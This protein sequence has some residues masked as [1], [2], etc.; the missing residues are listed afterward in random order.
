MQAFG[1][2]RF[3]PKLA[4]FFILTAVDLYRCS[5]QRP[6]WL[7]RQSH[8]LRA[9]AAAVTAGDISGAH[10]A[11]RLRKLAPVGGILGRLVA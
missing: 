2:D 7:S 10:G 5:I 1:F 6:L 4:Q 8:K 11:P 3:K 9:T